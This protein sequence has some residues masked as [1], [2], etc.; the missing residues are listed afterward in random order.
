MQSINNKDGAKLLTYSPKDPQEGKLILKHVPFSKSYMIRVFAMVF[1]AGAS[2]RLE[3]WRSTTQSCKD[4]DGMREALLSLSE[5]DSGIIDVGSAGAVWRFITAIASLKTDRPVKFK[6]G[7]R[8]FSRPIAPLVESLRQLGANIDFSP[9][10]VEELTVYPSQKSLNGG[11]IGAETGEHSSQFLSAL[12][13]IGPY[14]SSPLTIAIHPQQRSKPYFELTYLLMQK[15][16]AKVTVHESEVT[17]YPS[18]Y[19]LENIIP[20]LEKPEIDWT[21]LSY[22]LGWC[23][24]PEGPHSLFVAN[25]DR[26]SLQGDLALTKMMES[27]GVR[28]RFFPSG[29]LIERIGKTKN[30]ES[31][32]Q[33]L[34]DNIDLV[35]TL[36]TVCLALERPFHFYRIG[37]LKYKESDRLTSLIALGKSVGYAI[38]STNEELFWEGEKVI[39]DVPNEVVINPFQ[40]HRIAM[41]STILALRRKN[42][43]LQTPHVV[44]KSYS[45]FWDDARTIGLN[46]L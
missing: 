6:G 34:S 7:D 8:L 41:A 9:N 33:D 21:A 22:P 11:F 25:C 5:T 18:A 28:T 2:D 37:A 45:Y 35:P 31:F 32:E 13:L 16:G 4:I 14:L 23:A 3:A 15:A 44:E 42:I 19:K 17:V 30:L 43:W 26:E 12:M 20:L 27:F 39:G 24:M 1:L 10:N 40:D 29:V 46:T 38:G 36:F